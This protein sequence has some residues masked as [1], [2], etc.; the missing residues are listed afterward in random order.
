MPRV[1]HSQALVFGCRLV[2]T[3]SAARAAEAAGIKSKQADAILDAIRSSG[4]ASVTKTDLTPATTEFRGEM[5][6]MAAEVRDEIVPAGWGKAELRGTTWK[7]RNAGAAPVGP[8][9]ACRVEKVD[10]LTLWIR[11]D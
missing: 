2:D 9:Q 6:A 7:V 1:A 5:K 8:G 10:G 11:G 4:E 3:L